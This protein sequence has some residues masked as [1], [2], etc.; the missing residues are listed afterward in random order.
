MDCISDLQGFSGLY[1]AMKLRQI[2]PQGDS[3]P[4][5]PE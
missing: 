1:P 3:H 2:N 4:D 5:Y